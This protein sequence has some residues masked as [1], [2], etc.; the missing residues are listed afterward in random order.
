[1]LTAKL[2]QNLT[3]AF[4]YTNS[5]F[6]DSKQRLYLEAKQKLSREFSG[7]MITNTGQVATVINQFI[8][9]YCAVSCQSIP[10]AFCH[11]LSQ[12]FSVPNFSVRC[13]VSCCLTVHKSIY[14]LNYFI[15]SLFVLFALLHYKW[16]SHVYLCFSI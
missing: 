2:T 1:M 7:K 14:C 13:Y 3:F 8:L 12:N 11:W 15:Y 6:Y 4:N 16:S 5:S 10:E 9:L